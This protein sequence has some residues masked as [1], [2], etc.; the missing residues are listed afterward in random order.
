MQMTI[1]ELVPDYHDVVADLLLSWAPFQETLT[2][3]LQKIGFSHGYFI[4][5]MLGE[6]MF[7]EWLL[8]D[9]TPNPKDPANFD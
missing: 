1:P 8:D 3:G 9:G 4:Y 6:D 2:T 5:G 7:G